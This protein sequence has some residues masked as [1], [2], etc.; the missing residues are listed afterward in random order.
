MKKMHLEGELNKLR[1]DFM[2]LDEAKNNSEQ[3][4]RMLEQEVNSIPSNCV[5]FLINLILF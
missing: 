5:Q 2:L 3:Q 1:R 4:N